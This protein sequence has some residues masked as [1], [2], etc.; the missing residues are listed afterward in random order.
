M[1][2]KLPLLP[3]NAVPPTLMLKQADVQI[4]NNSFS[5]GRRSEE[6]QRTRIQAHAST[7]NGMGRVGS[8]TAV[9]CAGPLFASGA[10]R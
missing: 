3:E 4:V 9:N 6:R 8:G 2:D 7:G 5:P 10:C 1:D